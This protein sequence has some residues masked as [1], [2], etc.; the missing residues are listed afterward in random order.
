MSFV[1]PATPPPDIEEGQIEKAKI[2]SIKKVAS[3][4][5]D[6]EGNEREQLEF[7]LELENGF[8]CKSWMAYYE[9][10]S[11]KSKLGKLA[12]ALENKLKIKLE[13][14]NQFLDALRKYRIVFVRCKSFR[15]YEDEMYPN[16][17]IVSEMLPDTT[18]TKTC[19]PVLK[20]PEPVFDP[21]ALLGV[22][23]FISAIQLGIPVNKEDVLK[24]LTPEQRTFLS[25]NG[26]IEV[27]QE[28]LFFTTKAVNLF[29]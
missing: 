23:P 7:D 27:F 10:P 11:D 19:T 3:K 18:N 26:Y 20:E 1:K 6:G 12:L 28:Q 8:K 4:W 29:Q 5:K 25:K 17:S 24:H 2:I 14:I 15:E 16:F 13:N 9:Q 22:E 21:K